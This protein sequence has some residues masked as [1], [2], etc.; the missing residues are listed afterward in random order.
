M[1]TDVANFA[2]EGGC[3]TSSSSDDKENSK[4]AGK[5]IAESFTAAG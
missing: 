2:G 5:E 1:G 3:V 4:S